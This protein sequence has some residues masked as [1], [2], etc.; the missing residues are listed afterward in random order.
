MTVVM[1]V[2]PTLS[3]DEGRAVLDAV[4]LDLLQF[5]GDPSLSRLQEHGAIDT[6]I[7][8][9]REGKVRFI[10]A[11]LQLDLDLALLRRGVLVEFLNAVVPATRG[12]HDER[13]ERY[14]P[15]SFHPVPPCCDRRRIM[16]V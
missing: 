16:P 1:F 12:Q 11:P 9:K 3:P 15:P 5:H 14:H 13:H 10:G 7:D 6:M 4:A 2:G 8:L